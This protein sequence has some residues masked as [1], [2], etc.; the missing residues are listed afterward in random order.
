ML[1]HLSDTHIT[2]ASELTNGVDSSA[3][4]TRAIDW[5]FSQDLPLTACIVTG[6]L[7][8]KGS[9]AEYKRLRALTDRLALR[10]PV[11]WVL[12][13]HD[14]RASFF[15]V[16]SDTPCV[17]MARESGFLQYR[18]ALDSDTDLI[19]L[20]SLEPGLDGGWLCPDRL[21]WL[22]QNLQQDVAQSQKQVVL[23]VHHPV[24]AV[25]NAVFD[26]MRLKNADALQALLDRAG[27]ERVSLILNGH[28]HR[29]IRGSLGKTPV[30]IGASSAYPYA[31][32]YG[33]GRK[34]TPWDE[35]P[36]FS[37]HWLVKGQQGWV[38]H[39]VTPSL[40]RA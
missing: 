34:G 40:G 8:D 22:E 26:G 20:D 11:Y 17:A 4:L 37:C 28:V 19:V 15:E 6:D 33:K 38:S 14:S 7:V 21:F 25:G 23:A 36:G 2:E 12:G 39:V 16:F 9:V 24:I 5:V 27:A 13:N 29:A 30:W 10:V 3:A 35:P 18:A 32:T 31:M 1:L